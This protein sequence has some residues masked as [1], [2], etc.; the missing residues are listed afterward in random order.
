MRKIPIGSRIALLSEPYEDY[1]Y[2]VNIYF[3]Q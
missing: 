3:Y 2:F 1:K